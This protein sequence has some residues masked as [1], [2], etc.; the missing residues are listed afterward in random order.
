MLEEKATWRRGSPRTA[1][2][3]EQLEALLAL[4]GIRAT[5]L[6]CELLDGGLV[7][8]NYRL[9]L[10]GRESLV[11]RFYDRDPAACAREAAL[12]RLVQR[13]VPVPEVVHAE[14]SG[15]EAFPPFLLSTFVDGVSLRSL[16]STLSDDEL[17]PPAR[18][19]GEVLAHIAAFR[20]PKPGSLGPA[21]E[22]GPWFAERPDVIPK[23]IDGLMPRLN[24]TLAHRIQTFI[25]SYSGLLSAFD[26]EAKLVH[27]DYGSA[28]VLLRRKGDRWRVAA[29]LDWEFAFSGCRLWDIG[30]LLRYERDAQP[31]FE[32]HFSRGYRDGGGELPA[33]WRLLARASDLVSL[34][35]ML[36]RDGVP[37]EAIT[38]ITELIEATLTRAP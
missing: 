38:E 21:L 17:G 25:G 15:I 37:P 4:A 23:L 19:V 3:P 11:L 20:F 35:E 12:L 28:N 16:K 26:D 27:A 14:R 32:P 1:V 36:T 6:R 7:N 24:R 33:E 29:V 34:C 13:T 22:V 10:P 5:P 8:T 18:A 30:N 2:T 9:D 31:R